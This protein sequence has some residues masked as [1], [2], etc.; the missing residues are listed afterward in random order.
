MDIFE[1]DR[2]FMNQ[3]LE[4]A[5]K[6]ALLGEVPIGAVLVYEGEIIAR[7][8]NLRET[9]QNATT[10]AELMVIQEACKK[11]GSWRLEQ[12]TL[13]VTLEPC[14]MCAGAIL[15]SRV[16]RVVYGA[17]D[18]KAGCVDS[19]YHL[20]NDARFNHDCDVTEG[21]LAEEC[22]QILTDFFR[23]LRERKKAEKKARKMAESSEPQ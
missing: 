20:L 22:G 5:K 4:E 6:A 21:I 18:I 23:A 19:L 16:P 1:K 11:L 14:P 2:I 12:T 10:H 7:A 17:R 13:Y 8:H 9:T 3:A 15:Q